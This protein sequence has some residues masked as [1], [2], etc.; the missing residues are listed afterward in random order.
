MAESHNA[1]IIA[2]SLCQQRERR[3]KALSLLSRY[4]VVILRHLPVPKTKALSRRAEKINQE[5]NAHVRTA[6]NN[7]DAIRYFTKSLIVAGTKKG[8][9]PRRTI[10]AIGEREPEAIG[11]KRSLET[12]WTN[13][14][15]SS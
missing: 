11:P 4:P 10:R 6:R 7:I 9:V 15:R 3:G 2:L 1:F 14:C 13:H 5:P 12:H 8:F